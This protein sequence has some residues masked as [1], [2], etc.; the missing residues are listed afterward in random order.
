MKERPEFCTD[1]MLVFLDSLRQSGVTNMFGAAPYLEEEFD[2]LNRNKA[3]E[4][5]G[6]WMES[7]EKRHPQEV[8]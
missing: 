3:R 1:E 7:F 2:E 4:T 5:L 8:S 6:Y